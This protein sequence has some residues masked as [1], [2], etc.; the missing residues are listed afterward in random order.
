MQRNGFIRTGPSAAHSGSNYFYF[1]SS[2]GGLD[3]ATAIIPAIDL[4]AGVGDAELTFWM[5]VLV[6]VLTH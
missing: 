6:L 1:E 2:T 4:T 3:T 5:H